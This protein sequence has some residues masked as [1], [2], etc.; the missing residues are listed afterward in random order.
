ME[1]I[2]IYEK[3]AKVQKGEQGKQVEEWVTEHKLE[4]INGLWFKNGKLVVVE[5][6]ELRRGV[7]YT[8]HN[9]PTAGHGGVTATLFSIAQDYWWPQMKHFITAYVKGCTICQANKS[10]TWPNKPPLFPIW[11]EVEALPF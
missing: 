2:T 4:F 7:T 5:D 9:A 3:V 10:N 8:Y 1:I 11:P 6:N